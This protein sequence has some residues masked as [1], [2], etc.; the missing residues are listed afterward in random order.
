M[1]DDRTKRWAYGPNTMW[2]AAIERP[3][4]EATFEAVPVRTLKPGERYY[5]LIT[6]RPADKSQPLRQR[7]GT[8]RAGDGT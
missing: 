7:T 4:D 6:I 1:W 2:D 3:V 8:F 5:Y